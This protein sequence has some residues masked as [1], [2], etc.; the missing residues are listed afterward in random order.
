[1][2]F[3]LII[4]V[5]IFCTSTTLF[6]ARGTYTSASIKRI[7]ILEILITVLAIIVTLISIYIST[8]PN[9][10]YI[11]PDYIPSEI[12]VIE[13]NKHAIIFN[14]LY[15]LV[16]NQSYRD[17]EINNQG[18]E[19]VFYNHPDSKGSNNSLYFTLDLDDKYRYLSSCVTINDNIQNN[20]NFTTTIKIYCDDVLVYHSETLD[21]NSLP[22][23]LYLDLSNVFYLSFSIE[24][25]MIGT[26]HEIIRTI[27]FDELS[28]Q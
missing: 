20:E 28:I 16:I 21:C 13:D 9:E 4:L 11:Y 2:N 1:M 17:T 12:D 8:I 7:R 15:P 10:A 27:S 18:T 3:I 5:S 22:L 19:F 25:N 24:T 26:E 14:N 6:L 23:N